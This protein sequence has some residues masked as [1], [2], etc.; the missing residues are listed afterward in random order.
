MK[1]KMA[2]QY[3]DAAIMAA[4]QGSSDSLDPGVRW[5][6]AMKK[7]SISPNSQKKSC[8]KDIFLGL[9]EEG[10]VKGTPK[11]NY[12]RSK[13]N[14]AYAIRA[15]EFLEGGADPLS[16]KKLW[17]LVTNDS[18]TTPNNQMEVVLA[19]WNNDLIT[20]ASGPVKK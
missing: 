16:A 4:Q 13:K 19:L 12:T 9:C 5:D 10:R 3:G 15:L 18:G 11:G 20:P 14:K 7:L 1:V 17:G 2:N 8:P 6:S